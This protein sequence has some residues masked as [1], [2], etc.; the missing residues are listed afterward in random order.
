MAPSLN[1]FFGMCLCQY[2]SGAIS[3]P[4]RIRF[5]QSYVFSRVLSYKDPH[6]GL[7]PRCQPWLAPPPPPFT[8]QQSTYNLRLALDMQ[9]ISGA[10]SFLKFYAFVVTVVFLHIC[11]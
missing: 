1:H 5:S 9:D 3:K 6:E 11:Y 8:H 2:D 10:T 4:G 7:L